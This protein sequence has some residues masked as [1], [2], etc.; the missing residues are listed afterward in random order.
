[1]VVVM[2]ISLLNICDRFKDFYSE[3]YDKCLILQTFVQMTQVM[4]ISIL[5]TAG[6]SLNR[7]D[8]TSQ[9]KNITNGFVIQYENCKC[10]FLMILLHIK[11][12]FFCFSLLIQMVQF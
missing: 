8:S 4:L 1:M 11:T 7:S 12:L 9:S 10:V 6:Y 5:F 2:I 3:I